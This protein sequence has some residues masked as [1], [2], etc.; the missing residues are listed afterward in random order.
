MSRKTNVVKL[1][2][3]ENVMAD[4]ISEDIIY[5]LP[6]DEVFPNPENFRKTFDQ[7]KIDELAN[8]IKEH[9]QLS[10]IMVVKKEQGYMII[11]GERRWRAI[12]QIGLPTIKATIEEKSELEIRELNLIE[13]LQREN[14]N[15]IDEAKAYVELMEIHGYTQEQLAAKIGLKNQGSISNKIRILKLPENVQE[16]ISLG[17]LSGTH[18]RTLAAIKNPEKVAELADKVVETGAKVK[19]TEDMVKQ[20]MEEEKKREEYDGYRQQAE[21][22][23]K[24]FL[25]AFPE[26]AV[27]WWEYGGSQST[28]EYCSG[29]PDLCMILTGQGLK[30]ICRTS[31]CFNLLRQVVREEEQKARLAKAMEEAEKQGVRAVISKDVG[32]YHVFSNEKIDIS[33]CESCQDNCLVIFESMTTARACINMICYR[34]KVDELKQQ[35]LLAIEKQNQA[36]GEAL[37]STM[38][39]GL[40]TSQQ[41]VVSLY[42][43]AEALNSSFY[44]IEVSEIFKKWGLEEL[45]LDSILGWESLSADKIMRRFVELTLLVHKELLTED[46]EYAQEEFRSLDIADLLI[47]PQVNRLLNRDYEPAQEVQE[48][49]T[50][51]EPEGQPKTVNEAETEDGKSED[52]SNSE[53]VR[54]II[55][56]SCNDVNYKSAIPKLTKEELLYCL[57]AENR[58]S[59]IKQLKAEANKR[60]LEVDE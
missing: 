43:F 26:G 1:E 37:A 34:Q 10:S 6:V 60:G 4:L 30:D 46:E 5:H 49:I 40:P 15:P 12:K 33:N 25:E 56:N 51:S 55:N 47:G 16:Y 7:D 54:W 3:K 22:Q 8:S 2:K 44:D 27:Q 38:E 45:N 32:D 9:G 42:T 36:W 17:K 59:G 24:T 50:E 20:V 35:E 13:N 31:G 53:N 29:C 58:K 18:A 57:K 39:N 11:A 23:G 28:K 52:V 48:G 41:L 19:E 21:A 14:L